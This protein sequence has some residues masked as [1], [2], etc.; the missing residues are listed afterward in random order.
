MR[1]AIGGAGP[2]SYSVPEMAWRVPPNQWSK[3]VGLWAAIFIFLLWPSIELLGV[4]GPL[5]VGA[6]LVTTW[7]IRR[8]LGARRRFHSGRD[9]AQ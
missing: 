5:V 4:L 8:T 3:E 9:A 2:V 1:K 7:N 6:V